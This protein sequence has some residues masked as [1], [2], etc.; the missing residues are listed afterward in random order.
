[1]LSAAVHLPPGV[2]DTSTTIQKHKVLFH[3]CLQTR[4]KLSVIE[5]VPA[6]I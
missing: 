1:M 5:I 4:L 3:I 2:E 6:N